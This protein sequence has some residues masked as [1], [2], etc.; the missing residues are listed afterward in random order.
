MSAA[1]NCHCAVCMLIAIPGPAEDVWAI[2]VMRTYLRHL[3]SVVLPLLMI[4]MAAGMAA[5]QD[6]GAT[7]QGPASPAD[8]LPSSAGAALQVREAQSRTSLTPWP[9]FG[10]LWP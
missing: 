10:R 2:T 3:M 6:A 7:S 9:A 8:F 5:T 1:S 4:G